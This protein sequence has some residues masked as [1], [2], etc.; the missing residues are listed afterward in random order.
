MA[1]IS[2]PSSSPSTK[3]NKIPTHQRF[4]PSSSLHF[5]SPFST[6]LASS[7]SISRSRQSFSFLLHSNSKRV[8]KILALVEEEPLAVATEPL[9][10]D[11]S[12][13]EEG[14]LSE[15]LKLQLKPCELYVCNIPRSCDIT[16]LLELF[17]PFGTVQSVEVSRNTETGISRGC[18][19]VTMTYM[20]EAKAAIAAL[21][22]SDLGG[23]EMRVRF[24]ADI[25]SRKRNVGVLNSAPRNK[26]F[27]SPHKIYVGNLAWSVKPE[28][29]REHFSQCG[30]VV[31]TRVMYDRKAGR[32]RVYGFLS[33]S[34][35]AEFE[36]ALSLNGKEYRERTLL[37]R[38]VI[39]KE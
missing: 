37:V 4:K 22:G 16:E 15:A 17:K 27:E 38:E 23:R 19:Y 6:F 33:F 20:P 34:S 7:I 28:D 2:I 1:A 11:E 9:E 30:T 10:E 35:A 18:G 5:P 26:I 13:Y 39:K 3:P 36:A 14:G 21:D 25:F 24:S 29:L 32:T 8:S 31:S 12:E